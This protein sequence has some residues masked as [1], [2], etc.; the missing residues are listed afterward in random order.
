MA[1]VRNCAKK[2]LTFKF[3][4]SFDLHHIQNYKLQAYYDPTDEPVNQRPFTFDMEF[5]NLPTKQLRNMIFA[6]AVRFKRKMLKET[7]L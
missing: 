2:V 4:V 6:E 3:F 5:D 1:R 7:D